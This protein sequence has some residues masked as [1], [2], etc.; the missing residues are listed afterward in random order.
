MA[1]LT[2]RGRGEGVLEEAH[3]QSGI[4]PDKFTAWQIHLDRLSCLPS[5]RTSGNSSAAD[6]SRTKSKRKDYLT[7]KLAEASPLR[8]TGLA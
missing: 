3:A 4:P 5:L 6:S 8:L 7:S 1:W 2:N